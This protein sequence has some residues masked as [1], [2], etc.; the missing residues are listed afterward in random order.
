MISAHSIDA[1]ADPPIVEANVTVSA[2]DFTVASTILA[3]PGITVLFGSSGSGKSLTLSTIAGLRRPASGTV[4]IRG[5]VVA[6]T[7]S[8]THVRT[9]DRHVG[10]VFQ[11]SLLLPHRSVLDNVTLAVRTGTR[12]QRRERAGELLAVVGASSL[13]A[14]SPGRLS[15]GERQRI[16]LARALA[17]D[18]F[19]LLLDEP[20]S[21]LDHPTRNALRALVRDVVD[22][23]GVATLLVTH[24][25][26]EAAMLA[27][28]TILFRDGTTMPSHAG[29][30]RSGLP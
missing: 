2:G 8:R 11:D 20:F 17:G 19:V 1:P 25:L 4:S 22:K 21:A 29:F 3:G 5:T 12:A 13:R 16:A 27:D 23:T 24:D 9:Q 10:M 28:R 26:D 7:T 14:A 6:D 30:S 18:P 15:G